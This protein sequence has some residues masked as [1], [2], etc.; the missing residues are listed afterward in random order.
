MWPA[1]DPGVL[2]ARR[3]GAMRPRRWYGAEITPPR[4]RGVTLTARQW[5][6]RTLVRR[7]NNDATLYLR[8]A[9]SHL[10]KT[11]FFGALQFWERG[12]LR[13]LPPQ[14]TPLTL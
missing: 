3:S 13:G 9:S 8:V 7:K 2:T 12:G 11:R 10:T 1:V 14:P 5:R 6:Y 4:L